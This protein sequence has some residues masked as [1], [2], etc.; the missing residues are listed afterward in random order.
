MLVV[1]DEPDSRELLEEMLQGVGMI[2][3]AAG[4]VAEA[5]NALMANRPD[6]IISDIGM[7]YENGYSFLRNLRQVLPEDGGTIPAL[8]LTGFSRDEDR[9][10]A[11]AA[12]FNQHL[13]KPFSRDRVLQA[14]SELTQR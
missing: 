7:P 1:E 2:V 12:G 10:R 14:L 13:A 9:E 8:A 4:T 3:D 5:F 11:F 6:V